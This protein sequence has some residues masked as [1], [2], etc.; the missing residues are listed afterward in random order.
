MRKHLRIIAM[1]ALML[2]V[3]SVNTGLTKA[4]IA[5]N[6]EQ[7]RSMIQTMASEALS[8]ILLFSQDQISRS[9]FRDQFRTLLTQSFDIPWIGRFVLGRYYR[10]ATP[11]QR[12]AYQNL[13]LEFILDTYT[14]RFKTYA[15]EKIRITGSHLDP[16]ARFVFVSSEILLSNTDVAP[17][18]VVWRL[19]KR[20]DRLQ[21]I[22]LEI[23][24]VSMVRTQR[25][26]FTSIIR[27]NNG[28][29]QSILDV[30]GNYVT[31]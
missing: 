6:E 21:V 10:S 11:E 17:V 2:S 4:S 16:S 12:Q 30:L 13:F 26:E 24:N 22:D 5:I 20:N 18:Q 31:E 29:I 28:R 7:A 19:H 8:S 23:E 27:R 15:N 9:E 14:D 25:N 1:I 3:I